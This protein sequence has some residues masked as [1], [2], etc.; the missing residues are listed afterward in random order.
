MNKYNASARLVFHFAHEEGEKLGHTA[1]DPEHLLL[2]LLRVGGTASRVLESAGVTL[3][4]AR[5]LTEELTGRGTGASGEPTTITPRTNRVMERAGLEAERLGSKRV[6]TEHILLAILGEG[7]RTAYRVLGGLA[8]PEALRRRLETA[9]SEVTLG[10][11]R[12]ELPV[13]RG[14]AK[15]LATAAKL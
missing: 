11:G 1:I 5:R 7:D 12:F 2:G 3:D 6:R 15:L 9:L 14:L 4:G 8:E 13:T 10:R